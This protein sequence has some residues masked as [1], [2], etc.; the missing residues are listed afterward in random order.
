MRRFKYNSKGSQP[1]RMGGAEALV[2]GKWEGERGNG[3]PG[4]KP[5]PGRRGL[6]PSEEEAT[7]RKTKNGGGS[8]E[9]KG[10]TTTATTFWGESKKLVE[11]SSTS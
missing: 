8:N 6:I 5:V 9:G 2:I 11:K 3:K 10:G 1:G 7:R 4:D